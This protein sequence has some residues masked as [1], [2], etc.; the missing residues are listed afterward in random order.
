V[1][2]TSNPSDPLAGLPAPPVFTAGA[3]WGASARHHLEEVKTILFERHRAQASGQEIVDAYTA[4][5]DRLLCALFHAASEAYAERF[6]RLAQ[7]CAVIAQ[8]GYGRA[9]LNPC[10][11]IDLLFL[12]ERSRGAYIENV[13][14]RILYTLWDTGLQVGNAMRSVKECVRLAATDL[15]VKTA[16]LDARFLCGDESLHQTFALAMDNDVLKRGADRFFKEKLAESR[17]RHA[18]YGDSVYLLE[19]HLK[20]GEGGLR[21]L[22]TALWMAKVKFKTNKLGELVQ[23]SVITERESQDIEQARDFLFRVRNGLHFITGQ[24]QDQL[25]FEYQE[26]IAADLGFAD[27]GESH[28][29][30][31]FMR[32]Y[33]LAAATVGRFGAEIIERCIA[34]PPTYRFMARFNRREIRPGV[35]IAGGAVS[36]NSSSALHEDPSNL[37]RLFHD[38]QRHGL[39]IS[40]ATKRLLRGH[41]DILDDEHRRDPRLVRAFFDILSENERVYE[42]LLEMHDAGVLGAFL[43]EFGHLLCMVRRDHSH[44]YTVDQHSLRGVEE[45]EQLRA[46]AHKEQ[47]PLLTEVMRE[48][49][50]VHIVYL[51]MVLHDIGKGHGS[52]HS[53][54]GANMIPAVAERLNLNEDDTALL[55]FLVAQHLSMSQLAQ[56]RDIHD[57]KLIV[58]FARQ[59][60]NVDNLKKLYVLTF[61]DMRAV[62]PRIWNSWHDMLMKE[63]FLQTLD[64][65][66]RGEFAVEEHNERL[67]RV[68]KRIAASL[69]VTSTD[70]E[71]FLRDMPDRYFLGTAE[72]SI[73][74]HLDLVAALNGTRF[75]SEVKHSPQRGFS[76]FTVVTADR[77]GLFAILTGVLLAH[78]MNI[79]SAS[80]NT[81]L[82][83]LAVDIFRISHDEQPDV[84]MRADRWERVHDVLGRVL[85][86]QENVRDLVATAQT[87]RLLRRRAGPRVREA[88]AIDNDVSDRFTVLDI[89]SHDRVGLLFAVADTLYRLDL[90]VHLAKITT[91]VGHVLD[92]FY[93]TDSAGRKVVEQ[94]RL[95]KIAEELLACLRAQRGEDLPEEGEPGSVAG[96]G[97]AT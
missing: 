49:D 72:E 11:D 62:G 46:G 61:A 69:K 71:R 33:Y 80:I 66:E 97:V 29:V 19:P 23:K 70:T 59:V 15:K 26:R 39:P 54:R 58:D 93:V 2:S 64:V 73:A 10:S 36:L 85:A 91:H 8:G 24:H 4:V 35:I 7:R 79:L 12:C 1:S 41:L 20:E 51:S 45:L 60:D 96:L 95:Q 81:S 13:A 57:Q 56:G 92:V 43:P 89:Y 94:R 18:R 50:G 25:R 32:R 47:Y 42:T 74:H 84:A 30:E 65:L 90:S 53:E 83:G 9:E 63:L 27:S 52:R 3:K 34:R 88:V 44:I 6:T 31:A 22:H 87:G 28:G 82:S 37:I 75:V 67:G 86:G 38:A 14:E 21:D 68:K 55:R 48:I 16:L 76:E 17:E 40:N 5:V 78:G 77:P